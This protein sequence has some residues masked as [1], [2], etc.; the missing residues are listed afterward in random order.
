MPRNSGRL[1]TADLCVIGAGSGGLSVAAGASQMGARTVLI[2]RHK[3]G[4]E[5]LNTGCVPSKALLAAGHA[6]HAARLSRGFG[7]D[8]AQAGVDWNGVHD[9]IHDVIATIA[10]NDSVARFEGLGVRVIQ[11]EARFVAPD[12]LTVGELR[13]QARR[14]V[15]ATG[16]RPAVPPIPGLERVP[17]MTNETVFDN[18]ERPAHLLVLGGGAA[19]LELAQAHARLGCRVTVIESRMVLGADDPELA[20]VVRRRLV[21]EGIVIHEQAAVRSISGGAGEIV[22]ATDIGGLIHQIA[23]SHLLV[24][25]GRQANVEDLD[26]ATAGIAATPGGIAVDAR[27]RTANKRVFAVGD[28]VAG[29]PR[30]THVAGYHAGI[31]LRNALFRWPAKADH[32]AVP[33]V[34]YTAPELASVGLSANEA[35]ERRKAINVL[36]WPFAENDRARTDDDIDGMIKVVTTT[37]GRVLGAAI[38]GRAA[39]ELILPWVF[40]VQGKLSLADMAQ[41][42]APYPTLS[43]VSKRVAGSFYAGK[44]FSPATRQ[45]VRVLSWFG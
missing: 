25:T 31:V 32:G 38:V 21:G 15:I 39:G 23:G 4:G 26:L 40:A 20:S 2:E 33:R 12:A 18:R 13:V 8:G 30:F 28:V 36:R 5:C 29:A 6:I 22:L 9:Y 3:M 27:L 45:L 7:G 42:I 35:R 11:G 19:G 41:V 10:P 34:L 16:S 24:A 17:F 43:E 44:L 14:F 1:V 37:R